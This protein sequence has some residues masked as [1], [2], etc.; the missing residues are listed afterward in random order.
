MGL[1]KVSLY[2]QTLN[3]IFQQ[4]INMKTVENFT[5]NFCNYRHY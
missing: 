2:L 4:Y 3:T 1:L 5:F